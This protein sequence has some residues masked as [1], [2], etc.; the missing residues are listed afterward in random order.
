MTG[1]SVYSAALQPALHVSIS[2]G[3]VIYI[4]NWV[5]WATVQ[6]TIHH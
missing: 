4:D 6:G 1:S 2:S 3:N 5:V